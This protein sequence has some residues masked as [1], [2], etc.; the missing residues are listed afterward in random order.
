MH[1]PVL[2]IEAYTAY[3]C[4]CPALQLCQR[5]YLEM[6]GV[7]AAITRVKKNPMFDVSAVVALFQSLLNLYLKFSLSLCPGD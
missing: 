1:P 6:A 2:K 3:I 5:Y 7:R 4:S